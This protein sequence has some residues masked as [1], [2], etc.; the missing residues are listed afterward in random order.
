MAAKVII[1]LLG[2]QQKNYAFRKT[3][4]VSSIAS[5]LGGGGVPISIQ[6]RDGEASSLTLCFLDVV[7]LLGIRKLLCILDMMNL[8]LGLENP[9]YALQS[10]PFCCLVYT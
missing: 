5:N 2:K 4:Y 8:T 3:T 9:T 1:I 10:S 7:S 6:R